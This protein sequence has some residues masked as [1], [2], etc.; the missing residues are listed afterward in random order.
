[1][2]F[3]EAEPGSVK[4]MDMLEYLIILI[5]IFSGYSIAVL[6]LHKKGI[7][8]KKN[9]SFFGPALMWRT[10]RG[11]NFIEN[12]AKKSTL[13]RVYSDIGFIICFIAMFLMIYLFIRMIPSLFKIP[14]EQAPTPQMMLL[15]PG[16]N[17]LLPINSIL[18]LIIG[19]IIAVIA[20]EFSHGVL[21]RVSN[22]KIKSLGL[23]YM[24]I[25]L[26]AFVEPDE[27]EFNKAQRSK[28]IRVL[29]AGP[30]ANFVIAGICVIII[31]SIFVPF[32]APKS[33]GVVILYDAYDL[34]KWN[35]ITEIDG[36]KLGKNYY[37]QLDNLSLCE[38]HNITYFDG[39]S[40]HNK[41]I[42]YGLMVASIVKKSPAEGNLHLGDIICDINNVTIISKEKFFEIM[43]V[44]KEGDLIDIK[45]YSNGSFHNVSLKLADKYDFIKD[46]KNKGKGFLGIGLV[47]IGDLVADVNYFSRYLNPFKTN[48]LT[49]AVLPLLGLSPLPPNLVNLYTPPEIFWI[50]YTI[51]YWV[52]FIN[53]AVATFNVLPIVPLDG[54]YMINNMLEGLL[55]KLKEKMKLKI[56]DKKVDLIV[57]NMSMLISL[58]T[59]LLILMPF[60][61]PRLS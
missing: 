12:L 15:L 45:F 30:M 8:K 31:G 25:P 60:I 32:I 20:H 6:I 13:W 51:I 49:F 4:I 39:D 48:L 46:E 56:D 29:A 44:T 54:G 27:K 41:K 38:F 18:Y 57:K 58:L 28:K 36:E 43:N 14:A 23:L 17:P 7:L 42:F 16:I 50:L 55:F 5:A 24:I 10:E 33:E 9:I 26:G 3:I 37:N 52:F 53:F 35:L 61:I 40:Y 21:F 47:D 1:L 11:K 2:H 22:I 34:D 59:L 19:L